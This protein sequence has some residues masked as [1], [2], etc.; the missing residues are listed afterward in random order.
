MLSRNIVAV[1]GAHKAAASTTASKPVEKV[2]KLGNGLTVATVD[3]Q[4]PLTQLVLAFRAGSR[5]EKANQAGLTHTLRNFV[6]RDSKDHFG[7]AIVWSASNYGGV[8]KSFTS[9]DLFG[10]SVTVPRDS[11]SYAL[12][13]LAQAAANP[14]FKPWEIEDVLPTMRA[15][16]G[17]RTPY[18][19]VVDQ[20]HK[21]AYRNGGL[22]NSVYAPCSKIG[23]IC[24]NTLTE[25]AEKHITTGNAV[26]FT[27]IPHSK[28]E[29]L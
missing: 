29:A 21:A 9:R 8:V 12:H 3:S 11:S 18:D 15:D 17:Y 5:Y 7:S 10:V 4:K 20:I 14:G 28:T 27:T 24:T 6:G 26:L 16:N 23:A 13:V 1:R 2:T 22:G 25:F 19:L